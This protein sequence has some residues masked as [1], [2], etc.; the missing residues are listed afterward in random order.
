MIS[1]I[2]QKVKLRPQEKSP[3]QVTATVSKRELKADP[4]RWG[5]WDPTALWVPADSQSQTPTRLFS[6]LPL[7]KLGS[8]LGGWGGKG[9]ICLEPHTGTRLPYHSLLQT[10]G[11]G[12]P[13]VTCGQVCCWVSSA[14]LSGI[15]FWGKGQDLWSPICCLPFPPGPHGRGVGPGHAPQRGTVCDMRA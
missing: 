5:T 2:L 14:P 1:P 9:G 12:L 7:C 11:K 4:P 8:R 6:C 3:A 10:L 13:W 15:S